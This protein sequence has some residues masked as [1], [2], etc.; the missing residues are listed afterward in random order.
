MLLRQGN[1]IEHA[2]DAAWDQVPLHTPAHESPPA[3]EPS[4]KSATAAQ[5][6]KDWAEMERSAG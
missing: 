3:L 2:L 6:L 4:V 1:L 5:L